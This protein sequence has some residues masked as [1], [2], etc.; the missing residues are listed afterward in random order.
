VFFKVDENIFAFKTHWASC[1]FGNFYIAGVVGI[2][3]GS[4]NASARAIP[5]P[6]KLLLPR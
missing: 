6:A 1:V 3:I 5:L 2:R 4:C